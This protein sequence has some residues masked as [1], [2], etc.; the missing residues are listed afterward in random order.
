MSVANEPHDATATGRATVVSQPIVSGRATVERRY[1]V[2]G[3]STLAY[4]LVKELQGLP[5]SHVT[6]VMRG[7]F[8]ET[9]APMETLDGV[10]M[11]LTEHLDADVL[12]RARVAESQA[13]AFTDQDDIGNLDAALL[14]RELAPDVR[15]VTRMFDEVL[16]ESVH[17]LVADCAV[18]SATAVAAP[19]FVA[20]A[21]GR[22][23][24]IPLR[25]FGRSVF[26]TERDQTRPEDVLCGLAVT[27]GGGE[28]RVLPAV[29]DEADLVLAGAV[30]SGDVEPPTRT[31]VHR[32]ARR[33]ALLGLLSVVGKRLRLVFALLL[34]VIV[35]G[36][37][38]VTSCRT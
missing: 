2:C 16:A 8:T 14:A 10:D 29:A 33:R 11:V 37:V 28:P 34:L 15:I 7:A 35:I 22:D 24:A 36:T 18:L 31:D 21:V 19:A 27:T 9:D 30:V 20:A 3:G 4:R 26:V 1:I 23:A 17:D 25:L 32:Q 6:V 5:D 12:T 38:T 13:I